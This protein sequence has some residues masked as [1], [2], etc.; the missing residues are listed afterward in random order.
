MGWAPPAAA[1]SQAP[2]VP[3]AAAAAAAAE[4][5]AAD[6]LGAPTCEVV[7]DLGAQV[8][9]EAPTGTAAAAAE[10]VLVVPAAAG[11]TPSAL[12]QVPRVLGTG[13]AGRP[14][15]AAA[16]AGQVP[17]LLLLPAVPP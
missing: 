12:D 10:V 13:T 14:C 6:P 7:G 11:Q 15:A 16:A 1:Q 8:G 17:Q 9:Q 5:V 4:G 3:A 2:L